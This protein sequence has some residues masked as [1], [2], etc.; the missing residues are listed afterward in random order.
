[1]SRYYTAKYR[2]YSL[3]A[4]LLL[5]SCSAVAQRNADISP[6]E[7]TEA[8][9]ATGCGTLNGTVITHTTNIIADTTWAG[10]GTVHVVANSISVLAPATLTIAECAVVKLKAGVELS[11]KG[12]DTA[13]AKLVAAGD[14]ATTGAVYFVKNDAQ[15]WGRLH[16]V[17]ENSLI[18]LE[19]AVLS[20][21]GN[22][23][24][25]NRNAVIYMQG[26]GVLPDPVLRVNNTRIANNPGAAIYLSDAAFTSDSKALRITGATD[27]A[28]ALPAMALGSIPAGTYTGNTVN[29]ALVVE[30]A[31]IF[32]NLTIA[33]HLPIRFQA[34]AIHVGGLAP[35]FVTNLTLTLKSGVTLKIESPTDG[36]TLMTFGETGQSPNKN[37][38]LVALGTAAAPVTF[39]SGNVSPSPGDWAGIWLA[40]SAGSKLNHVIIEDAGGDAHIGPKSCGPA[41]ARHTAALLVGD[42]DPLQYVPPANLVKNSQFINNLGSFAIDSVWTVSNSTFGPNLTATNTFQASSTV[43]T[44]SRNVV[45]DSGGAVGCTVGGQD[46]RACL[47]P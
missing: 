18:D 27:F 3:M 6:D 13:A 24:G 41:S 19:F 37:A 43:C 42:N 20:G 9:A 34:A 14:H 38:A 47:V 22:M 39:T 1:M 11:V 17:N 44:Q 46:E 29:E 40:T 33:S 2:E 28:L 35:S 23:G 4:A 12:S 21:G 32:D 30:N 10:S 45:T 31:N 8:A 36:P 26:S 15:G 5:A 7:I 16:G 25:A